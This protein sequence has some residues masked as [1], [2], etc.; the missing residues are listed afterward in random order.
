[1]T[2]VAGSFHSTRPTRSPKD[3]LP[4]PDGDPTFPGLPEDL[5]VLGTA[6]GSVA[7][8]FQLADGEAIGHVRRPPGVERR[9]GV[10]A[11]YVVGD[12]MSPEHRSGDLRFVD[13]DRDV[14][15]GDSVIVQTCNFPGDTVQAYIKYL[16]A[17]DD[18]WLLL[19][20]L[21]PLG[22]MRVAP[23]VVTAVHRILTM[24][25]LFGV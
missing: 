21:N 15:I 14:R 19:G 18:D 12:S 11:I 6:A 16:K 5:P 4:T 13:P 22:E 3:L 20:Q 8:A 1:M 25:E 23:T 7:G 9:A 2:P 24:N 10:Y 17:R